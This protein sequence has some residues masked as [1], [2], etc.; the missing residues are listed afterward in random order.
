[1]PYQLELPNPLPAEGWKVKIHDAENPYEDPH[2]TIYRKLRKWR[3]RL[4]DGVFM[5]RG[6]C[7]GDIDYRVRQEIETHWDLLRTQWDSLHG[8]TNPISSRDEDEEND[9]DD[10]N[11]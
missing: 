5:D 6:A 9:D 10:N 1:M 7:W 11:E 3:L 8:R 2:V 4:R